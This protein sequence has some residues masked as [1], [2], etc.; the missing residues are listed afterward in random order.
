[1]YASLRGEK[2]GKS[3]PFRHRFLFPGLGFNYDKKHHFPSLPQAP[4][5]VGHLHGRL[6][7]FSHC[8]QLCDSDALAS[9]RAHLLSMSKMFVGK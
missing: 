8:V 6:F 4:G 7:F 2:H 3:H 5:L 1:M 9:E